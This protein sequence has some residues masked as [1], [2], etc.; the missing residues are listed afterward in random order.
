MSWRSRA[1]S[2]HLILYLQYINYQVI[3]LNI[4]TH[5]SRKHKVHNPR[6]VY[7]IT[8][9]VI[10]WIY[11]FIRPEYKN[12]IIDSLRYCI[13]NKGLNVHAYVIMTSHIHLLI[14]TKDGISLPDVIRD[15]KT[16]TSKKLIKEI[17]LINES[18]KL[19]ML[20]KF[21]FEANRQKRG[22][23][24]K[25]WQDG[26]HPVE[27]LTGEMLYQKL[28][29]IHQNPVVERI[30]EESKE[31]IYSSARNYAGLNGELEI[32]FII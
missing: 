8:C 16:F 13:Q 31:Y 25:L 6:G 28:D 27:I 20:N 9:T 1:V 29:Y 4:S 32:D 11:L 30:V 5:M 17:E 3:F 24:Y 2:A 23:S 26:Y 7:F 10:G 15:F 21:A 18:R 12:I 22:K 14:S 19:W